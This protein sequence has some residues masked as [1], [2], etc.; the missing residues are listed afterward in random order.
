MA[1]VKKIFA[2]TNCGNTSAK[3]EGKC[4]ACGEW[5]TYTE[6]I[7]SKTLDTNEE[8]KKVW[9]DG[10][11]RKDG[12][13]PTP[14]QEITTG[15]TQRYPTY[16]GELNRVLGGGIVS[17]SL[18]LI[19]GQPGIGKSTLML[20]IAL[21]LNIKVLYVSGEESEEQIKMRADRIG[22]I[23]KECY[24]LTE[25]NV[26]KI[27]K[28][29][30]TIEP[31]LIVL[32]SIQTV[33]SPY[34][35]SAPG[36]ISQVRECAGEMQR[37]AKETNIPVF[38]IGHITKD[39][40]IAGPKLLE[41]IV[42]AVLQFEGDRHNTYRI[43]RTIKN[44]FGSTAEMGIYEM[45]SNGLRE[46]TNPSELLISQKEDD[47]SGSAISA[48]IEGLRPMLIEAQALV[49]T[50]VY[51]NPQRSATGFD[52]RRLSM[53][54]A[55]LEKRCNLPLAQFD[56]FLNIAGGIRVDDPAI[57]LS[58]V[59]A[60]ISSLQDVAIPNNVCF[61]G[62]VGLSGEVRAVNRID[63]RIQEADKLGF[64][65]IFISKYNTKGLDK[66]RYDINI[67]TIGKVEELLDALFK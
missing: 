59:A 5:N 15:N 12:P 64:K 24:I 26:S 22:I 51:G 52:M 41:H 17:G 66:N 20:Q 43:L 44:R 49:S 46:V 1:K 16:D 40:S 14:L 63:Q 54:L 37:F 62:E 32:D 58:I 61:A 48:T 4:P 27:L 50:A 57:D 60:L 21:S 9:R 29:A 53:L 19:G 36:S 8:K 39:G 23:N 34:I 25:T 42:D 3:W 67:N 31:K 55:V 28:H 47:L 30:Q 33:S 10:N 56:V 7:I 6:E 65:T 45:L 38:V 11:D 2:C 18:V 13:K 35:E